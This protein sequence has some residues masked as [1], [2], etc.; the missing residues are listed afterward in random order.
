MEH[1]PSVGNKN[2]HVEV[3]QL[4]SSTKSYTGGFAAS[5]IQGYMGGYTA[6]SIRGYRCGYMLPQVSEVIR[7]AISYLRP[8]SHKTN[9]Q[10]PEVMLVAKS[11]VTTFWQIHLS[12]TRGYSGGYFICDHLLAR[13]VVSNY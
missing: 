6:S 4:L 10:I 1:R 7:V 9:S 3:S 11:H 5:S 13:P 2:S 12:N 8:P